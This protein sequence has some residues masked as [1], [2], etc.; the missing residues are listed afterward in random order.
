MNEG[1]IVLI[2]MPRSNGRIKRRPALILRPIP[3]F[4]DWLACGISTQLRQQ[5]PGFD[6]IVEP[7]HSDFAGSGLKSASAIRL[8]FLSTIPPSA[9]LG[10]IGRIAPGRHRRLLENLAAH[11]LAHSQP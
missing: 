9:M 11:L 6:E 10:K 2:A 7:S 3:P 5:V 4:G 8:G 1:D